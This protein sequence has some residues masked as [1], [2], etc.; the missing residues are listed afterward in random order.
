LA[1][2]LA[3]LAVLALAALLGAASGALRQVVQLAAVGV[4][5]LAARQLG[6]PVAEGLARSVSPLVARAAASALLFAGVMALVSLL[7][8]FVLRAT[9]VARAVRSPADRGLGALLGGVKGGLVVWVLLSALAI[10]GTA[11]PRGLALDPGY[12]QFASL[13]RRHN[14][15]ERIAPAQLERIERLRSRDRGPRGA[16]P[17]SPDELRRD[18][19]ERLTE[20]DRALRRLAD[21]PG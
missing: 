13:A 1:L 21:D 9:G 5:W 20:R 8:A 11:A 17:R 18:L 6:A 16:G 15:L 10:A 4:G 14:L 3:V 19:E 7:G 12:S 2:D